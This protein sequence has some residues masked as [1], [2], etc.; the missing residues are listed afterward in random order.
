MC[1][2]QVGT[3]RPMSIHYADYVIQVRFLFRCSLTV[4]TYDSQRASSYA[5]TGCAT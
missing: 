2:N 1:A 3:R 4:M 5:K